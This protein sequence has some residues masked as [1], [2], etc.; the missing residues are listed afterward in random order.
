M[1][2]TSHTNLDSYEGVELVEAAGWLV[3]AAAREAEF[4][5]PTEVSTRIVRYCA[6]AAR[7]LHAATDQMPAAGPETP[8]EARLSAPEGLGGHLPYME[9]YKPQ[10]RI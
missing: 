4:L 8:L 6:R 9:A 7:L 1:R 3:D 10:K 2:S 5:A